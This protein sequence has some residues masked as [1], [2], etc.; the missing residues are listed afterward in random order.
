MKLSDRFDALDR[1]RSPD[2]W[3]GI[4]GREP[5]PVPPAPGSRRMVAATLALVLAAAG[6]T[7]AARAFIGSESHEPGATATIEPKSNG[8]IWFRVGGGD[9]PSFIY[10]VQPDGTG[11]RVVFGSMPPNYSQ[12]AWSPDGTRIAWVN[13]LVGHYGI[14]VSNPDGTDARQ[15]TDG[16]NDGWPSW[17]PDGTR[18]V[19]S[20]TRYDSSISQ[21]E[22][23]ADFQCPTDL[24]V[25]DVDGSHVVRLTSEPAPEY[26]PVWSPDGTRIA[27]VKT[28]NGTTTFIGSAT[29]IFVMQADGSDVMPVSSHDGGSDFSPSW[30][31]D[32]RQIAF[33][34]IRSEDWDIFV[35]NADGTDEHAIVGPGA[36]VDDPVWSPDGRLIA[37]LQ[38]TS[39][40]GGTTALF[41][42]RPDSTG[43]GR[44]SGPDLDSYGVAGDI[45][46]QPI[47]IAGGS[48]PSPTSTETSCIQGKA[49]GD[50]DGDGTTDRAEFI[51]IV[52]GNVSCAD[53]GTVVENLES[54]KVVVRFGSSRTLEERFAD[55]KGGTC[56]NIFVAVDLDGDGRDELA[57]DVGPGAAVEFLEFYRVGE[58]G[59]RAL[60]VAGPGDPPYVKEGPAL[61]GGGF[62]TGQQSPI[63]CM[64]TKDGSRELVSI[65]AEPTG[66]LLTDPWRVHRTTMAL[67]GDQLT[68]IRSSDRTEPWSLG[69]GKVFMN[70]C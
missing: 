58:T 1:T 24:Y 7:L 38:E 59:L 53:T 26:D 51:E 11:Q 5:R 19:F 61:L 43:I 27:F 18:I 20:S 23:G 35:V 15:L 56:A 29:G 14:Y 54:Q 67:Q 64:V 33:A 12:I 34:S 22:P 44:L 3:P 60:S 40:V 13:Y 30:S 47:P 41:V 45:A 4:E 70:D 62:D 66:N 28:F 37:F 36:Y 21:C 46:W 42:M 10:E 69:L 63:A 9:G 8:A 25:M 32:G 6:I 68:V 48:T 65:H 2:L 49:T 39:G 31:P 55:C 57:I 52:S 17:S 16:V 50:F